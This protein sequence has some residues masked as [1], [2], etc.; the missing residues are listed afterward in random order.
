MVSE[1]PFRRLLAARPPKADSGSG[2][3]KIFGSPSTGEPT[4]DLH[5]ESDR[6]TLEM[7]SDL[8]VV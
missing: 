6:P 8:D 4:E 5:T 1:V 7:Q 2:E 3:K